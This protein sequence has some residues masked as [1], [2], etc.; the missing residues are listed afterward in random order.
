[1]DIKQ[2]FSTITHDYAD[3]SQ[4]NVSLMHNK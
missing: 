1:M 3:T 2:D 4:E